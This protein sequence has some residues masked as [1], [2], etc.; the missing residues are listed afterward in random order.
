MTLKVEPVRCDNE[1]LSFFEIS[2]SYYPGAAHGMSGYSGVNYDPA[3]GT[4]IALT[5]VIKDPSAM[6]GVVTENIKSTT[7]GQSASDSVSG[8]EEYFGENSEDLAWA[9]DRDALVFRFAPSDIAPYALGPLE[10]RIPFAAYPDLFTGKYGPAEGEFAR[11]LDPYQ[12]NMVDLDGD[13]QTEIVWVTGSYGFEDSFAYEM[14]EVIV[15]ERGCSEEEYFFSW[16]SYVLH[17]QDGRNFVLT[18]TTSDNDYTN[19]HVFEIKNGKPSH[20]GKLEG[21]GFAS[22]YHERPEAGDGSDEGSDDYDMSWYV[23]KYPILSP[24]C[25]A[26]SKQMNLMSTYNTVRFYEMGEDGMP[27]PLTDYYE[28]HAER[29]LTSLTAME[30]ELVDPATGERTGETMELTEGSSCTLW[31]TNGEDYVDLLL[32][33]GTAFRVDVDAEWPQSVNGIPLEEAFGGTMFAG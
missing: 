26:L 15:G 9:I 16:D 33:D 11:M 8:L 1:I 3:A 17:T 21:T 23:D 32:E 12:Q 19:L 10:A 22:V 25:F 6:A 28:I 7:D 27:S 14:L 13:G 30:V 5:D 31:R 24:S 29:T 20:V 4:P 18:E 2:S